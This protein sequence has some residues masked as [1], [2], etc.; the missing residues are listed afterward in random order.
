MI[1]Q[2]Q[3]RDRLITNLQKHAGLSIEDIDKFKCLSVTSDYFSRDDHVG[4]VVTPDHDVKRYRADGT[5]HTFGDV[6]LQRLLEDVESF[7]KFKVSEKERT[8]VFKKVVAGIP[9]AKS[10][11][12]WE[13]PIVSPHEKPEFEFSLSRAV[14]SLD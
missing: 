3:P 12:D 4:G 13:R 10:S 1:K 6:P 11:P 5:E 8:N 9:G 7:I 14:S 2:D